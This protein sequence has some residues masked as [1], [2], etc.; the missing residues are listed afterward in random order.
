MTGRFA[1]WWRQPWVP[2]LFA[3]GTL[4]RLPLQ[5]YSFAL[6]L[7]VQDQTG[8]L[9][10]AGA[11][12][13][14]GAVGYA[15]GAP[16]QGRLIDRYGQTVP[17]V[18]TV[19][20]NATVFTAL[21]AVVTAAGTGGAALAA[22]AVLAGATLPPVAPAQRTLWSTVVPDPEV[23]QIAFTADTMVLDVGLILGPLLVTGVA[24][25]T[26]PAIALVVTV[27][28]L[29]TGTLWFASLE[30]SRTHEGAPVARDLVGPLR[31]AGTRTLIIAATCTGA[32]I[33]SLRVGFVAVA[34]QQAVPD[35]GGVLL[36]LFG[37]GS[38]LGGLAYGAWVKGGD[39]ARRWITLLAAYTVGVG[40]VALVSWSMVL[41][42]VFAVVAGAALAPQVITEFELIPFC[43]P[44]ANVTE[45]YAW[46][47]TATF[48]GD[49]IGGAAAAALVDHGA[50]LPAVAAVAGAALATAVA[51]TWR[52]TLVPH[53]DAA[54]PATLTGS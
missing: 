21:L 36:S 7:L 31:S 17:L 45:A 22:L 10:L 40:V 13:A 8:S 9:A 15:V 53:R 48:A 23:R 25:L 18:A 24:A 44:P 39:P 30:P 20:V 38:L 3:A 46:G 5:M 2:V 35:A 26:S 33:G 54:A 16:V 51:W 14:A 32:V 34:E 27:T 4:G 19:A 1:A 28:M 37:V 47:I 43:A 11:V 41:T 29:V 12:T 52:R 50:R 42:A 49:A 6:L